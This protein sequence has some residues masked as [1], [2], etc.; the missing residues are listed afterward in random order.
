M[1]NFDVILRG[2]LIIDGSGES[3]RQADLGIKDDRIA[4]IETSITGKCER[5]I[6]VSGL[7][8]APG[9]IDVH[10]H[11]DRAL[12]SAPAMLPKLTQGVT[13]VVIGNC[14]ISLA[15]LVTESIVAPLDLIAEEG[16]LRYPSFSAY[17]NELEKTEP[18]VN[19]VS[20]IGHT[21]LRM[22]VMDDLNRPANE[23]ECEQMK[24][25][26]DEAMRAGAWGLSTGTFY[27]PARAAPTEEIIAIGAPLSRYGGLYATHMRNEAEHVMDSL[28]ETFLIGR[29]LGVRVV[30]SH[31][32][33]AGL[34]HHGRS[35][36]TLAHIQAAMH[37]QPVSLDCY[38]YNAS[39]TMLHPDLIERAS[40]VLV[41]W[42]TAHPEFA[43]KLLKDVAETWACDERTA[44]LRLAPAGAIYFIMDEED[45]RRIL[46]FEH[47]MVGSDGLPH[48]AH[49]HPRLW[50]TFPRVLGHYSRDVGLFP[51]EEAIRKMTGLPASQFGLQ[52]RGLLRPGYF[53]DIVAFD[54]NSVIDAATFEKPTTP[55]TGIQYVFVNGK[56][57]LGSGACDART[58]RVLRGPGWM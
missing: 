27:P 46:A 17:L 42:S 7:T 28:D 40:S 24:A 48:D 23:S 41:A 31:H 44:A 4:S 53:A 10:T 38:P 3:G 15:P 8:L 34:A 5:E 11:D 51:L 39:S 21:T 1:S 37:T 57:S 19:V 43:G 14:G 26:V 18:A 12:M 13:T 29:Q 2:G 54:H 55:A 25:L 58:G 52:Q 30:I 56:L 49:P 45:V 9:F 47:T 16:W 22:N 36:E 33:L 20:L 35:V 6:D 50:G 32:K